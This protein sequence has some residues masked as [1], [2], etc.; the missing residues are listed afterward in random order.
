MSWNRDSLWAKACVYFEQ[1]FKESKN[2]PLFGLW[3]A[4]GLELVARSA[5]SSVSPTL[6]AE[7]DRDHKN[8][9]HALGRGS[10]RTPKKSIASVQVLDLCCLLFE[11]FTDEHKK[12]CIA[13]INKRNEELHSGA[14]AFGEYPSSQWLTGFYQ[15]CKSLCECQGKEL[16]ELF[17]DDEAQNAEELLIEERTAVEGLV[18]SAIAAHKKVFY[19][20]TKED[21]ER[22]QTEAEKKARIL[23]YEGQHKIACPSCGSYAS[24]AGTPYGKENVSHDDG[25]IVVRQPISPRSFECSACGLKFTGYA[26]LEIAGMGGRHTRTSHYTPEDYFGLVSPDSLV[27]DAEYDNE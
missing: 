24:V 21:Q 22:A 15:S 2:D 14:S 26:Q 20:R 9:L 16:R 4:L 6:L 13:I 19:S 25:Y 8:L 1:A 5:V 27:P 10:E 11:E 3:A 23:A 12:I 18:K 7:P 17:G